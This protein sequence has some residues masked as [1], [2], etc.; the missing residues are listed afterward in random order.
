MAAAARAWKTIS[1]TVRVQHTALSIPTAHAP[2][3]AAARWP[4]IPGVKSVLSKRAWPP[5]LQGVPASLTHAPD[6]TQPVYRLAIPVW[7]FGPWLYLSQRLNLAK[8]L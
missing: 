7:W 6:R 3:R 1:Q 2:A 5:G 8:P 4:L